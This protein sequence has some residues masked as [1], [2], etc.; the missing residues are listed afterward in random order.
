MLLMRKEDRHR[1]AV[2]GGEGRRRQGGGGVC[3]CGGGE[4]VSK[5]GEEAL[6]FVFSAAAAA[7]AGKRMGRCDSLFFI[8]RISLS[9]ASTKPK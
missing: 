9:I 1:C 2:V 8:A 4:R 7:V 3:V 6:P 5:R